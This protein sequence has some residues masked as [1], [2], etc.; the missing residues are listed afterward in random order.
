MNAPVITG[1][2][3]RKPWRQRL[4][5]SLHT[6]AVTWFTGIR[7]AG[8]TT[9]ARSLC[10][11][12]AYL[13]CE[14]GQSGEA[15]AVAL[16]RII[17]GKRTV[18]IDE[19]HRARNPAELVRHIR[20]R[21]PD[22]RILAT[23]SAGLGCRDQISSVLGETCATITLA[24][25]LWGEVMKTRLD[26]RARRLIRGG[27]PGFFGNDKEPA[28]YLAWLENFLARDVQPIH[29]FRDTQAV[30]RLL[31]FLLK[32]SGADLEV[33][34]I[35][36]AVGLSTT[37][38]E[39]RLTAIEEARFLT[40]VRP[41]SSGMRGPGKLALFYAFDPGFVCA[42][43]GWRRVSSENQNLLLRHVVL[44]HIQTLVPED[45]HGTVIRYW[46]DHQN[47]RLDFLVIRDNGE[48][49]AIDCQSQ[50]SGYNDTSFRCFRK[51]H[52]RGTNLVVAIRAHRAQSAAFMRAGIMGVD[53]ASMLTKL[54]RC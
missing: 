23:S 42:A 30:Q 40:R 25:L 26:A 48:I 38:I 19:I 18:I 1:L 11:D 39:R 27:L 21:V 33:S 52:P 17:E 2:C 53:P 15:T 16:D 8:K 5:Q 14:D 12:A 32:N 31:I 13:D 10:A 51:Y 50:L 36:R 43:R 7:G 20:Q 37:T 29:S 3:E 47:H 49:D 6:S 35:S 45:K 41:F 22:S 44:Q 24:P 9:L 4:S 46:R 28:E 34:Q 54:F